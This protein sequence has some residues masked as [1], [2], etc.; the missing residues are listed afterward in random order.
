MTEMIDLSTVPEL[1]AYAT[2]S[3]VEFNNFVETSVQHRL[4]E[5]YR[6]FIILHTVLHSVMFLLTVPIFAKQIHSGRFWIF[7]LIPT[8]RGRILVLNHLDAS[9]VLIGA[10]TIFDVG[11]YIKTILG[12]YDVSGQHGLPALLLLRF[13]ILTTIGWIFLL[14]FFLV[15][16]P[17][18]SFRIPASIWNVGIFAAPFSI[19]FGALF[20]LVDA[21][22]HWN[23]YWHTY[24]LL[25]PT[26]KQA[27]ANGAALPST[28]QISLARVMLGVELSRFAHA[29]R[30]WAIV[31]YLW[32][33]LFATA[34]L[35]VTLNILLAHWSQLG[36]ADGM[37]I[38]MQQTR[39]Y[40]KTMDRAT[41]KSLTA[42][43][44]I[45]KWIKE[46]PS[47]YEQQV[48]MAGSGTDLDSEPPTPRA[49]SEGRDASL[50]DVDELTL[51][52]ND[53]GNKS[54]N[55]PTPRRLMVYLLGLKP[56][57]KDAYNDPTRD[58]SE[59]DARAGMRS[60]LLHT[61]LQGSAIFVIALAQ[62]GAVFLVTQPAFLQPLKTNPANAGV[63]GIDFVRYSCIIKL[64]EGY[65][66]IIPG[67]VLISSILMR[68]MKAIALSRAR[69]NQGVVMGAARQEGG[70]QQQTGVRT[71]A[72]L[73]LSAPGPS[74]SAAWSQD[75]STQVYLS[76]GE[77]Q[78]GSSALYHYPTDKSDATEFTSH[79]GGSGGCGDG[80]VEPEAVVFYRAPPSAAAAPPA[81]RASPGPFHDMHTTGGDIHSL[82]PRITI[83]DTDG[84][85]SLVDLASRPSIDPMSTTHPSVEPSRARPGHDAQ[86][87]ALDVDD[88]SVV[89][90]AR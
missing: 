29:T 47:T 39:T 45:R 5:V 79:F 83:Y 76:E 38:Q 72:D 75:A 36:G 71:G 60:L 14:G 87:S 67:L 70:A 51:H 27:L 12:Y 17:P 7:R 25:A 55:R 85:E 9:A 19:H 88:D 62:I 54:Q 68:Q 44:G 3:L 81:A 1:P 66:T 24:L 16:V 30:N 64:M 8:P 41:A 32:T 15:R 52:D 86:E 43:A 11:Y 73:Q 18:S 78:P 89:D 34:T 28:S 65:G 10:F 82:A 53:A 35:A 20:L 56:L 48:D 4:P 26:I 23:K 90:D 80:E 59:R 2:A 58:F 69:A 33:G 31:Y 61:A 50:Q 37:P 21:T 6:I 22:H 42:S 49:T 13:V 46:T 63:W 84:Q 77:G 74:A 40:N 57:V